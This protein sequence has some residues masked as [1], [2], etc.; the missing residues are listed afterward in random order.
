MNLVSNVDL[1]YA[2]LLMES[3]GIP[4]QDNSIVVL[5]SSHDYSNELSDV[6]LGENHERRHLE[7]SNPC[8]LQRPGT[9]WQITSPESNIE[10][11]GSRKGLSSLV[12]KIERKIASSELICDSSLNL[13]QGKLNVM[14]VDRFKAIINGPQWQCY[15]L[16]DR[17]KSMPQLTRVIEKDYLENPKKDVNGNVIYQALKSYFLHQETGT[18]LEVQVVPKEKF[19]ENEKTHLKH[20]TKC[21]ENKHSLRDFEGKVWGIYIF[22][23]SPEV[24][25]TEFEL[26]KGMAGVANLINFPLQQNIYESPEMGLIYSGSMAL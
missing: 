10:L 9:F 24:D 25:K 18:P 23:E 19:I 4:K 20:K 21:F 2:E 7:Y 14:D 11:R 8:L 17:I 16:M 5:R 13:Y 6:I 12:R 15:E 22:N 1:D 3:H 26:I